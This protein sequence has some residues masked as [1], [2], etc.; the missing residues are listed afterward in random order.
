MQISVRN[1]TEIPGEM[2]AVAK[3]LGVELLHETN[4]DA[5]LNTAMKLKMTEPSFVHF[6]SLEKHH[7]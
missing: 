4:V 2:K 5:L 1:I 7:A 3:V 6:I